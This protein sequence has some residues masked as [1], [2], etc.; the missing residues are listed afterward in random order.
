[1]NLALYVNIQHR[2]LLISFDEDFIIFEAAFSCDFLEM[3]QV[4]ISSGFSM[5]VLSFILT[6]LLIFIIV[7]LDMLDWID[8]FLA[9]HAFVAFHDKVLIFVD[10]LK[11]LWVITFHNRDGCDLVDL[12]RLNCLSWLLVL[13]MIEYTFLYCK[14]RIPINQLVLEHLR[15][16]SNSRYQGVNQ[17]TSVF[18]VEFCF[19]DVQI[20]F[21]CI[22]WGIVL[23]HYRGV[24]VHKQWILLFCNSFLFFLLCLLLLLYIF[25]EP[26]LFQK[27]IHIKSSATLV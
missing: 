7:L 17:I 22:V 9:D 19:L 25:V 24:L 18:V 11:L 2:F 26:I 23:Y 27:C 12:E 8:P 6:I 21:H 14:V 10:H 16:V 4:F 13:I 1:M 3:F 20:A 5:L 15:K